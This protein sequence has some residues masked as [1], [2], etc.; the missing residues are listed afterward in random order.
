[1]AV[2]LG[3]SMLPGLVGCAHVVVIWLLQ[4]LIECLAFHAQAVCSSVFHE[5]QKHMHEVPFAQQDHIRLVDI[6]LLL[7]IHFCCI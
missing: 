7:T 3:A 6:D 5:N 4:M 2:F 1:M